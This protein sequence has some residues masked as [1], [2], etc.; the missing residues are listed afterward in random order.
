MTIR[1]SLGLRS[2]PIIASFGYLLPHRGLRELIEAVALLR[3]RYPNIHLL[4]LNGLSAA[5]ES[6][7]IRLACLEDACRLG[8]RDNL[9]M[10]T[11]YLNEQDAVAL[12]GVADVIAYPYQ[13]ARE[14]A[15]A[16]VK[17]GLASLKPVIVTPLDVFADVASVCHVFSGSKPADIA[18]GLENVLSGADSRSDLPERQKAWVA[19]HT[20]SIISARLDGLIRGEMCQ[21]KPPS[22]EGSLFVPTRG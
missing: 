13:E 12:L 19:G 22:I 18:A 16:A 7:D 1:A 20:W 3:A 6:E 11:D 14:S 10:I 8:L 21:P 5:P 2:G 4:M 9:T 17:T 15:S